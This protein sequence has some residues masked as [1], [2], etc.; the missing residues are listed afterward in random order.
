MIMLVEKRPVVETEQKLV[1]GHGV[2]KEKTIKTKEMIL[3]RTNQVSLIGHLVSG[4]DPVNVEGNYQSKSSSRVSIYFGKVSKKWKFKCHQ[5][6]QEG[7]V[8]ALW[9]YCYG[10][11]YSTQLND[12]LEHMNRKLS[13]GL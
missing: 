3:Q 10:L 6:D 5:T 9:G 13:L 12:I 1:V 4:F 2:N 8:F 11:D 7:D